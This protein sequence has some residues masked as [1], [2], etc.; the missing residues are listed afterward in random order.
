MSAVIDTNIYV[1]AIVVDSD[2]HEKAENVLEKVEEWI[3]PKIVL[4]ELV[5]VFKRLSIDAG[6]VFNIIESIVHSDK[7]V[8]VDEEYYVISR[9][10][11][12]TADSKISLAHFND[13]VILYFAKSHGYP[14]YTFDKGMASLGKKIGA[15]VF[16]I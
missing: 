1:E 8:L 3:I 4:Y 9:A 10:L 5:W 2:F 15:K 6:T 11:R 16:R 12:F 14:V 7:A 13:L